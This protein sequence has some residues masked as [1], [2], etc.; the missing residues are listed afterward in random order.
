MTIV[1]DLHSQ[2]SDSIWIKRSDALNVLAKAKEGEVLKQQLAQKQADI[3]LLS[4]R[5]GVL[6]KIISEQNASGEAN[7]SIID[8]YK[9]EIRELEGIRNF[10]ELDVSVY[11]KQIKKLKRGKRWT[12][13]A[14]IVTTVG[15]L[16]LG[17][18]LN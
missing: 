5:I 9:S 6:N 16:W 4:D 13:I 10:M 2:P 17:T 7:Q 12:A 18:S 3:S 8:L 14:G 15:A 1:S 11:K